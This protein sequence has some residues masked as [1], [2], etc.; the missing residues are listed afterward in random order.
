M[1]LCFVTF[2]LYPSYLGKT[3]LV[4]PNQSH[5][6]EWFWFY[7]QDLVELQMAG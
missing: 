3:C 6:L 5:C 1:W 2:V 7:V 4:F